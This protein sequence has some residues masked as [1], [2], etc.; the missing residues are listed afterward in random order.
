MDG[1]PL[2]RR[3]PR[4]SALRARHLRPEGVD[5]RRRARRG[6][7]RG[8]RRRSRARWRVV[9]SVCE[10]AMEGQ[11]LAEAIAWF[12]PDVGHHQ[13]AQRHP[14]R[15]RPAGPGQD[16]GHGHRPGLPRRPCRR[17]LN[18]GR[19][20]RRADRGGASRSSTPCTRTSGRRDLTC[21]DLASWPYPSV[22]TVAG[23]GPG[24][25]RLP[26]PAGRDAG[27]VGRAARPDAPSGRGRMAGAPRLGG[28]AGPGRSSAAGRA[29]RS[30][31]RVLPCL[32]DRRG[33]RHRGARRAGRA[34]RRRAGSDADPLLVLHQRLADGRAARA[35]R[36]SASAWAS[37]TW[38][39]RS[40]ST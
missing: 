31:P 11:A 7:G 30:T 4:R 38:P 21:I 37:S 9:A 5:R 27:V 28:A 12:E 33:E 6:R 3:D 15:D 10:E 26:V 18:A 19:G 35:S 17:G 23:A 14:P 1:R 25:L 32:V 24:P 34:G 8:A 29:P 40:T 13:R 36:R 39:T 20:P 2:R 16:R 22:S